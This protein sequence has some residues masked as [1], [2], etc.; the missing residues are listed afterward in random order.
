[1]IKSL[2]PDDSTAVINSTI[3]SV[4]FTVTVAFTNSGPAIIKVKI[5]PVAQYKNPEGY[6]VVNKMKNLTEIKDTKNNAVTGDEYYK[7][8]LKIINRVLTEQVHE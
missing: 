5:I 7:K 4:L 6:I 1:M 2:K 3:D 8:R